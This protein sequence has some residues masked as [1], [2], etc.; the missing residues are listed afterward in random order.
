MTDG[1]NVGAIN[2][3]MGLDS[4]Q[5]KAA[6]GAAQGQTNAFAGMARAAL[7][8]IAVGFSL[9]AVINE[10]NR[11]YQ[12]STET[13]K[14]QRQVAQTLLT[15]GYASGMTADQLKT[16]AKN[17]DE[18]SGVSQNTILDA[19]NI[20]LTFR[21]INSDIFPETIQ[22]SQDMATTMGQDLSSAILQVGKALNDPITGMT[23]LRR[24]GVQFT[25][26]Q[27]D[28]IK[29]LVRSGEAH[30]AQAIILQELTNEF[31]GAAKAAKT[32][33]QAL[34][35][36]IEDIRREIGLLAGGS[37]P[38]TKFLA[39]MT[40]GFKDWAY[41]VRITRNSI[42]ELGLTDLQARLQKV[43]DKQNTFNDIYSGAVT[44]KKMIAERNKEYD[45]E[46][47]AIMK[48]I[49]LIRERDKANKETGDKT[50]DGLSFNTG[51]V[52]QSK[53]KDPALTAY[54][55]YIKE[56]Q[57]ANDDY[58]GALKAKKYVEDTLGMSAI[59]VDKAS[60]DNAITAYKD[61]Y[62]KIAEISQSQAINKGIL[63][64]KAEEKLQ[65]DLQTSTL[66]I[67][68]DTLIKQNEL[69][70][71]YQEQMKGIDNQNQAESDLGGFKGSFQAG[72]AQKLDILKWY[73]DERDKITNTAN[74]SSEQKQQIWGQLSL[75]KTAKLAETEK[76]IWKQRGS[77]ISGILSNSFDN[78]L[79]N[80]GGFG[81][82]MQQLAL[83]LG[84]YLIQQTLE[85][86]IQQIAIEQMKAAAMAALGVISGGA[87]TAVSFLSSLN[88]F[89]HHSGGLIPSQ[90]NYQLPGTQEQ[91]AMLKGGE[92][93]LSPAENASYNNGNGGSS[94]SAVIVY[95]PQVKAMDSKSVRNWFYENK[96]EIIAIMSQATKNNDG[97]YRNIIQA[98]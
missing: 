72:Y 52:A 93:V 17:M 60:Y 11:A 33:G 37:N 68:Q 94:G 21:N 28:Q 29:T 4:S 89:K 91:L 81:A 82:S 49:A 6:L 95:S 74:L 53:K 12:A 19:E 51:K 45:N 61:Y 90:A 22:L 1:Q 20:L 10:M 83:N 2:V 5:F 47:K 96:N 14:I 57:K 3:K 67:T 36:N 39:D 80:Y 7:G 78:M 97:G 8:G 27:K 26:E 9:G 50:Q 38:M 32:N 85:T 98:V 42:S 43:F 40:K 64:Q 66:G 46:T 73:Y 31:G 15:T 30:K 24:M 59:Q 58:T 34:T 69:I 70:K 56:F 35:T 71:G 76:D 65:H 88:P 75:V 16:L 86:A 54:E 23:A 92:R 48:Q 87:T 84:R 77:D 55:D 25:Q 63:L 41:Q 18:L 44:G 79:T 62:S 13:L